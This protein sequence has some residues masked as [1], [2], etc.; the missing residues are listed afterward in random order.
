MN[1]RAIEDD[2]K[3]LSEQEKIEPTEEF[4]SSGESKVERA[5]G[6]YNKFFSENATENIEEFFIYEELH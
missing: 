1:K 5:L 4:I 2:S 3:F 6:V